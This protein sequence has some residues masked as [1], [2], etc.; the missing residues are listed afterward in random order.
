ML[1]NLDELSEVIEQD[2]IKDLLTWYPHKSTIQ[3]TGYIMEILNVDQSITDQ[4]FDYLNKT[5]FFPVLLSARKGESAGRVDNKWK[6]DVNI[7]LESD[8]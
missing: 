2:D 8:L 5:K 7:K 1:A 4:L 3:R 6:V